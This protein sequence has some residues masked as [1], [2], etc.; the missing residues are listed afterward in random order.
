MGETGLE[1][2]SALA[3]LLRTG[4]HG[5]AGSSGVVIEERTGFSLVMVAARRGQGEALA[6]AVRE[7]FGLDLPRTPRRVGS[8]ALAFVWAGDARWMSVSETGF[9]GLEATLRDRLGGLAS[10]TDQSDGRVILRVSGPSARHVLGKAVAI[11]LHPRA[12]RPGDVALTPA[13][14][15]AAQ[16]WQVDD[17]PTY[18]LSV[19]RGTAGS[20]A[21]W[22]VRAAEEDGV[23]VMAGA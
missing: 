17:A 21:A 12:F 16:V 13:F 18:D 11:D 23:D 9:E 22:M 2:R 4:H 15:I 1:A 8:S 14:H 6:M 5:R 3:G 19:A 7:A 20:L 10:I